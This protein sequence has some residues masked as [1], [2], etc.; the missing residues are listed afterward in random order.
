MHAS[1]SSFC[2]PGEDLKLVGGWEQLLCLHQQ[3][4]FLGIS[5]S[6]DLMP[7]PAWP[8]RG[9]SPTIR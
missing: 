5:G 4:F 8:D 3:P 6:W 2:H 9:G 7:I 1:G